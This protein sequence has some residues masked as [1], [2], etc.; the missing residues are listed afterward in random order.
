MSGAALIAVGELLAL[1]AQP[2]SFAPTQRRRGLA[3]QLAM[4]PFAS[5]ASSMLV[6][7]AGIRTRFYV[8]G[9]ERANCAA[10]VRRRDH[11]QADRK[12][13]GRKCST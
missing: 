3:T 5:T 2:R 12:S 13:T 7:A 6:A 8:S 9:E 4:K 10:T 11:D 1:G